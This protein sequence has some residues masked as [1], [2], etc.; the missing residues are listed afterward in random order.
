MANF[1]IKKYTDKIDTEKLKADADKAGV[2]LKAGTQKAAE[3]AKIG[4]GK[5]AVYAK[6]GAQKA[7]VYA[8]EGTRITKV[9]FATAPD[10]TNEYAKSDVDGNKLL[11]M[12]S[13]VSLFNLIPL[14][15]H[16]FKSGKKSPYLAFHMNQGLNLAIL[17][18]AAW[19][20]LGMLGQFPAIGWIFTI[21]KYLLYVACAGCSVAGILNAVNGKAK[22]IP[23]IGKI[24][25]VD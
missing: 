2:V 4:A 20:L 15:I 18:F 12:V 3:Y 5:A 16:L 10:H 6:K 13:Y 7:Q 1:D 14:A 17:E 23:L 19:L 24:K 8:E 11:S 21:A 9:A 22:E 25:L